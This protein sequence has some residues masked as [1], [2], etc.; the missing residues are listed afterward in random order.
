LGAKTNTALAAHVCRCTGYQPIVEAA[1]LVREGFSAE[2]QPQ[3]DLDAAAVR[4]AL[5]GGVAQRCGPEV[6]LGMG[7]F[8]EDS[9]PRD[10]V[11]LFPDGLGGFVEATSIADAR[12][13]AGTVQGR[14]TT[15]S[16]E[17][18]LQLPEVDG[19]VLSLRTS[20]IEPAYLEPDCAWATRPEGDEPPI[21]VVGPLEN[22]GAF[23]GKA[24]SP[25]E[26]LAIEFVTERGGSATCVYNREEVVRR[27]PKR[28]PLAVSVD[29]QLRGIVVVAAPAGLGQPAV[30]AL[31]HSV[32]PEVAVRLEIVAGP[33]ASL[34][35]R[36]AV[37]AELTAVRVLAENPDLLAAGEAVT[38]ESGAASATVRLDPEG[39]SVEVSAGDPLDE[40]TLRSYCIGAVHMALGQ[41][42]TEGIAV[43]ADGVPLDLTFRSF[44]LLRPGQLPEITVTVAPGVGPAV[45]VTNCVYAAALAAAWAAAGTPPVWPTGIP[46]IF[47]RAR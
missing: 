4:A 44:G 31:V 39:I 35:L 45:G 15:S 17:P 33:P 1:E 11:V 47:E 22:G 46:S 6:A 36:G 7:G 29:A 26:R 41:V 16:V 19:A 18:P 20:W 2:D 38:V 9:A 25:V 10:G 40:T 34:D 24:T 23:G 43:G 37:W 27:G 30:E 32:L 13:L 42:W 14:N 21:Q 3:R 8:A 5:E 28:P 12:K